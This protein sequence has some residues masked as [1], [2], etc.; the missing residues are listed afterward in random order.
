MIKGDKMKNVNDYFLK[1]TDKVSFVELKKDTTLN[2][3]NYVLKDDIPLP[4]VTDTLVHGVK[5]GNMEEELNVAYMIEGIIY[6]LGIDLDFKYNSEYRTILYNFNSEIE[7]FILHRAIRFDTEG[8]YDDSA[9]FSR[10]LINI[11]NKNI[12]GIFNY[13]LSLEKIAN[14]YFNEEK[15]EL[16]NMFLL[17]STNRLESIL[18]ISPDYSLA[19]YKLGY[20]YMNYGQFQKANLMWDKF[21]KID[22]D[23]NRIQE[24]R[25]Q[26]ALINDDV[27]Y[28]KG[29]SYLTRGNHDKAL[30]IFLSLQQKHNNQ[31]NLYYLTGLAYKGLGEYED[32]IENFVEAVNLGGSIAELYNELGICLFGIGN[33]KESI[34]VLSKGIEID[35]T[36]YK[37]VFNRGLVYLQLGITDKAK[38]DIN[39]AYRLNPDDPAV[40]KA[41]EKLKVVE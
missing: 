35:E 21:I 11:N 6:V 12:K 41:I 10:A 1:M 3:N 25:E 34:D 5:K 4:I 14:R 38:E 7:D 32:A 2:I 39:M 33:T 36:N 16:A 31:W 37:I 24:I 26:L 28:E 20:H 22:D 29:I 19:Y 15:E 9:I 13:A 27:T 23:K 18:D 17:E 30:D 8:M 40:I